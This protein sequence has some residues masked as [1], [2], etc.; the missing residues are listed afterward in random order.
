V[1]KKLRIIFALT[2]LIILVLSTSNLILASKPHC[3]AGYV[4]CLKAAGDNKSDL[5]DCL[6]GWAA[7]EGKYLDY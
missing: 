3:G 7:C 2:L 1:G 6:R 4:A 5:D